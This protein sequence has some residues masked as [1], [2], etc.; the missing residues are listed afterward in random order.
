MIK[1]NI[2]WNFLGGTLPL[3]VGVV[4]FPLIIKLYGVERFGLL[5]IAWSLVGYFSLFDMGLSRALTQIVSDKLSK[6]VQPSEIVTTINTSLAVAWGLGLLGGGFL[7]LISDW[8]VL[9]I[10]SVSNHLEQEATQ[11]FKV[12]AISIPFVVIAS[13]LRGVMDALHLFKQASVIRV[14][15]GVST[16]VG[17]YLVT[18]Y[19]VSLVYA[20]LVLLCIRV[21]AWLMHAYAVNRTALMYKQSSAYQFK[22]LKQ[23]FAFGGWMTVSNVIG[24]LMVYFDRFVIAYLLGATAV[25]YYVAPYEMI[26]KL[27]IVPASIAGVL[28]PIFAKEWQSNPTVSADV[29]SKGVLYVGMILFPII[30]SI[31][32]FAQE[33]MSFWLGDDFAANSKAIL[34]WLS[35][36]ILINSFGQIFYAKIQGVGRPDITAKLHLVESIPYWAL[37]FVLIKTLGIEGAAI[38]WFLRV[39]AD[40]F[41][42]AIIVSRLSQQTKQQ[43]HKFLS[44]LPL[45]L[46]PILSSIYISSL[47]WRIALF[48][49]TILIFSLFSIKKIKQDGTYLFLKNMVLKN[50]AAN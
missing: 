6:S 41:W 28:F 31:A 38:A 40:T 30:L 39:S 25:A 4:I 33:G 3:L 5:A 17:P 22:L 43:V 34:G 8:L 49:I 21:V 24:P 9:D 1:K 32:S 20:V 47:S 19:D 2:V 13:M 23:L 11:A 46:L 26:T 10:L 50:D 7:W 29:L 15:L 12:L 42:L 44:F 36:G 14:F 37:L 48:L 45:L 18:F 27:W 35:A 16:F